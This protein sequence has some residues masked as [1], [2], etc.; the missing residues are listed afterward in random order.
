MAP[1]PSGPVYSTVIE[2][3]D[4]LLICNCR[5]FGE[6]GK[7]CV[8]ISA[9]KMQKQFGPVDDYLGKFLVYIVDRAY[10]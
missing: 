6:T 10:I 2:E 3:Q 1:K 5:V 9:V 7:A 8:H 4:G